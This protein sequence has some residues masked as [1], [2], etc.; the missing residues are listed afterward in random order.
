MDLSDDEV[1]LFYLGYANRT[2]WPL[3]HSFPTRVV[4]R[5][6][7]YRAYRRINRRF[8]ETLYPL[9]QPNDLI[10]VQD[11]HLFHLG[12]EL[13]QLGWQ[14]RLG[15][16]C[17][18]RCRRMMCSAYSPGRKTRWRRCCNTTSSGFTPTALRNLVDS[19]MWELGGE[20][21]VEDGGNYYTYD[22]H[23]GQL[24]VFPIGID[25]DAFS[26]RAH[27]DTP[28]LADELMLADM[29]RP[30]ADTRRRPAGLHERHT[31]Q[32]AYIRAHAGAASEPR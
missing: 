16:S 18:C 6:D 30:Q 19:L 4:I 29:P 13:R 25:P 26:P 22:G 23:T 27:T 1:S 9:L 7:T 12:Y 5:R 10:W 21:H 17:M 28:S 15:S 2:L 24:G 8:A 3:L 32:A 11:F 31:A 14:G 20:F